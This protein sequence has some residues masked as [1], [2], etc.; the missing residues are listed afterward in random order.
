MHIKKY[1]II[2]TTKMIILNFFYQLLQQN[3]PK[4]DIGTNLLEQLKRRDLLLEN[5]KNI[6]PNSTKANQIDKEFFDT[7]EQQTTPTGKNY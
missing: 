2:Y 5:G 4:S 6:E 1:E 3:R 7:L